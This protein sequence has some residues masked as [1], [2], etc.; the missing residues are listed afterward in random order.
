M[1]AVPFF[2]SNC[3]CLRD[4][5]GGFESLIGVIAIYGYHDGI[6]LPSMVGARLLIFIDRHIVFTREFSPWNGLV[7]IFTIVM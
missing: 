5:F 4:N 1:M 6:Y 3:A 2:H 7:G